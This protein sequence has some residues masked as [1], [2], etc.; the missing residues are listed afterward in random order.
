MNEGQ[1]KATP[2]NPIKDDW[3]PGKERTGRLEAD[4]IVSMKQ[5]TEMDGFSDLTEANQ[6]KVL[7]NPD[8]FTALSRSANASKGERSFS[9]WSTYGSGA[10]QIEVNPVLRQE[11]IARSNELS[12][13]LQNQI[14]DLLRS[15]H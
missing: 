15:Q 8:N 13:K 11:M 14:Y 2:D 3:L 7:N 1:P 12:P 10:N 9:E 5:I 4:H 6:L